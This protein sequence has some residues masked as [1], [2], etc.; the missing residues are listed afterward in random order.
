MAP[1]RGGGGGGGGGGSVSASCPDPFTGYTTTPEE[2]ASICVFLVVALLTLIAM[3]R[4]RKRHPGAK[5]ILGGIYIVGLLFFFIGYALQLVG[6]LLLECGTT[7]YLTYYNWTIAWN[8][9]FR[10]STFLLLVCTV[11]LVNCSLRE[12]LGHSSTY[13]NVIYGVVLGVIGILAAAL[14]GLTCYNIWSLTQDYYWYDD[15]PANLGQAQNKL[16]LAHWILYWLAALVAGA[17]SIVNIVSMRSKR[18]NTQGLLGWIIA[19]TISM[20]IWVLFNIVEFGIVVSPN[21]NVYPPLEFYTAASWIINFFQA[22]SWIFLIVIAKSRALAPSTTAD[23]N[24]PM[25]PNNTYLG[26]QGPVYTQVAQQPQHAY[27]YANGGQQH[28]YTQQ[29]V[30]NGPGS[31]HGLQ[32]YPAEV[33]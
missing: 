11:W 10:I 9:L 20:F 7:P 12:K 30:Y 25:Y 21:L 27:N 18:I 28:Y 6:T 19:L 23:T 22:L 8:I 26:P 33:K 16:G 5:R 2:F 32:P 17:L 29:P 15:A 4:V 1:R 24:A 14:V 3:F 31:I 13:F